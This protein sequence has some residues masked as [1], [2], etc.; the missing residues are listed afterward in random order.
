MAARGRDL[1]GALGEGLPAHVGEVDLVL[2]G[3]R[4]LFQS[5][6][7]GRLELALQDGHG[8][9]EGRGGEGTHVVDVRR[10]ERVGGGDEQG[11]DA[12]SATGER[13]GEH[14]AHRP[15]LAIE[16]ELADHRDALERRPGNGADGGEQSEGDG[17]IEGGALL[18]DVGGGEVDGDAV[19]REVEAAVLDGGA[20]AVATLADGGI[21]QP[22]GGERGEAG[23][24]VDL[25]VDEAG[26][27]TVQ[28]RGED[29]GEH[30]VMS[31]H[32][33]DA[34]NVQRSIRRPSSLAFLPTLCTIVQDMHICSR[35]CS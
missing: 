32:R 29:A 3:A 30:G 24:D 34:V 6:D 15:E 31:R 7:D 4:R 23:G 18:A 5:R 9:A 28:G 33:G 12:V 26:L 13:G 19:V 22:D 11:L 14:P 35:T 16:R 21:G 10:L 25:D 2:D 8:L 1:E 20:N 17:Q 27:N